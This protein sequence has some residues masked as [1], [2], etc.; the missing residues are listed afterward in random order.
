MNMMVPAPTDQPTQF[1]FDGTPIRGIS[2]SG[3]PVFVAA[4]LAKAPDRNDP[5]GSWSKRAGIVNGRV[6]GILCCC[7]RYS[8]SLGP[9]APC[10]SFWVS[11]SSRRSLAARHRRR[12]CGLVGSC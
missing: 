7:R 9:L 10:S 2:T 6:H 12:R 4:D 8:A 5:Q 11:G 3:N 1:E